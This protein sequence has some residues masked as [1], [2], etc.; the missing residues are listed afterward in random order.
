MADYEFFIQE[1]F[2]AVDTE[3]RHG[4]INQTT[5]LKFFTCSIF[6]DMLAQFG[7][8]SEYWIERRKYSRFKAAYIKKCLAEGHTPEPG[9]PGS[10]SGDLDDD[11]FPSVPKDE[12]RM[13]PKEDSFSV[14]KDDFMSPV[15]PPL[16]ASLSKPDSFMTPPPPPPSP[17]PQ[18]NSLSGNLSMNAP[19]LSTTN[20]SNY[21][22]VS[23]PPPLPAS[24]PSTSN[25]FGSSNIPHPPTSSGLP[26]SSGGKIDV[27]SLMAAAKSKT[28]AENAIKSALGS[29]Q[30][31]DVQATKR[32]LQ[33]ALDS[34]KDL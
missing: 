19:P 4:N 34:L 27:K 21:G 18:M 1:V 15:T 3:D 33:S 25:S 13:A 10:S 28:A 7:E 2:D 17:P 12:I 11:M 26:V 30:F 31:G 24:L 14:P 8:L 29:I 22:G 5:V 23:P 9:P 32:F 6:I 20:S 16:S